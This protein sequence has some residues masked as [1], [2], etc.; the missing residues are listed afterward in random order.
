MIWGWEI[1]L[2]LFSFH[3]LQGFELV[4][5]FNVFLDF[6]GG[7]Y[8][9]GTSTYVKSFLPRKVLQSSSKKS[10]YRALK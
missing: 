8:D 1:E 5:G 3:L 10:H 4:D 7:I 6:Q 9:N 2:G